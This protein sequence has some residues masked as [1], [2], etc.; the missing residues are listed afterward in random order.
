MRI[1]GGSVFSECLGWTVL[2][3]IVGAVV[4]G[5][6]PGAGYC[7]D[8]S[9]DIAVGTGVWFSHWATFHIKVSGFNS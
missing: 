4:G 3:W 6:R 5:S 9:K 1:K 2:E 7:S 8:Q